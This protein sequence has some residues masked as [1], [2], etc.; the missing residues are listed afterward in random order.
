[1]I[2]KM[3]ISTKLLQSIFLHWKNALHSPDSIAFYNE[4]SKA[5]EL[6][7]ANEFLITE[8]TANKLALEFKQLNLL[9][10]SPIIQ[11]MMIKEREFQNTSIPLAE[12]KK[13]W[14]KAWTAKAIAKNSVSECNEKA[15]KCLEAYIQRFSK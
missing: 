5:I 7:D 9:N 6:N 12:Q 3:L 14:L 13:V 11:F 8:A 15:D 4:L 1:M 10:K 2:T